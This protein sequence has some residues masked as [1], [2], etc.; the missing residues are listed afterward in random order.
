MNYYAQIYKIQLGRKCENYKRLI[1]KDYKQY[2]LVP[3]S[4]DELYQALTRA[5][6][7]RLWSGAPAIMEAV[8][9]TE[10]SLWDDSIC[11]RNI[12]FTPGQKIVQEWY[13]GDQE[14]ASIVTIILHPHK[15]GCSAEL[16]HVHI[17][18]EAYDN[19]VEGWDEHYFGALI[20]FYSGS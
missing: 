8:E 5:E 14:P 18:D 16:R 9:G 17:P 13:F 20:D 12:S 3:A 10:F 1:M 7:I 6:T 15:K 4:P 19:I 11:G 2:Y